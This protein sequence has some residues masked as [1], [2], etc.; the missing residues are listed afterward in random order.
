[1]GLRSARHLMSHGKVT[2]ILGLRFNFR[3]FIVSYRRTENHVLWP[4]DSL[5]EKQQRKRI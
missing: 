4:D 3:A 5:A 1:M 2:V